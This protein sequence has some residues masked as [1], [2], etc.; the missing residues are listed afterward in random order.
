M[1]HLV[2]KIF[3][4]GLNESRRRERSGRPGF[5]RGGLCTLLYFQG[6][7]CLLYTEKQVSAHHFTQFC[8]VTKISIAFDASFVYN[9]TIRVSAPQ[10]EG[11]P[12]R[13]EF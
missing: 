6:E 1:F 13:K 8:K 10:M 4:V 5:R 2:E 7:I 12:S 11:I 3:S 9:V